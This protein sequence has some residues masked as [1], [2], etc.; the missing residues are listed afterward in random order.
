MCPKTL[1]SREKKTIF[2]K[3]CFRKERIRTKLR[4]NNRTS[5]RKQVKMT[6]KS[7]IPMKSSLMT[8]STKTLPLSK[9]LCLKKS[10]T[11]T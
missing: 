5:R 9:L 4:I 3:L 2:R 10:P 7:L 6:R 11:L 1:K 8:S